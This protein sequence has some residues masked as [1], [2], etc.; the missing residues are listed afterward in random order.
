MDA[1]QHTARAWSGI[2]CATRNF[3]SP[4]QRFAVTP[5]TPT[6]RSWLRSLFL[7]LSGHRG[8]AVISNEGVDY[9]GEP[10]ARR[11]VVTGACSCCSC[12]SRRTGDVDRRRRAGAVRPHCS[13][14]RL[15]P[16]NN[17]DKAEFRFWYPRDAGA[18]RGV[19]VLNPG[20]NGDG[21]GDGGGHGVAGVR[22]AAQAGARRHAVH[23]QAARS[24]LHRSST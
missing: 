14:K 12:V 17:Y 23:R 19:I 11:P 13:T 10:C 18:L 3:T 5:V 16:G 9:A 6:H 2:C 20:S 21:R 7:L 8:V 4:A 22:D 1:E 15:P 24:G